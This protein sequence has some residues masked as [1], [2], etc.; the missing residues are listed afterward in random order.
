MKS[1]LTIKSRLF[2]TI[3]AILACSYAVLFFSSLF[4]IQTFIEDETSKDLELSLRFA[5]SQ[6]NA[7]PELILEVLKLPASTRE[8]QKIFMTADHEGLRESVKLWTG[9]LDFLEMLTILDSEQN[10]LVRTNRQQEPESFLRGDLLKSLY[11]RKQP[12]ITTELISHD[13]YCREVSSEVC[14]ALPENKDVMLQLVLLP[15]LD[16]SGKVIGVIAAGDDVNKDPHLPYQQQKVFGKTVDM[17]VTQA[18]ELIASTMTEPGWFTSVLEPKVL[19]VL[20]SG[21]AFHGSSVLNGH[22]YEIIAESINN[23]KGEFIGSIAVALGKSRFS[24][25][26]HD[27]FRNLII[28]GLFSV[29]AIFVFAYFV[30]RQFAAP[31]RRF[32]DAV[33]AIEAGDYSTKVPE[34]GSYEFIAFAETFNK[35][36]T[37][38]SQR[39]AIIVSQ[40]SE[41]MSL[42]EELERRVSERARQLEDETAVQK[43]II[44]SLVDGLIVADEQFRIIELNPAAEKLFGVRAADVAGEPLR[45]FCDQLDL[46][47]LGELLE[48]S[49]TSEPAE[50]ERSVVLKHNRRRLRFAAT[51]L[52]DERGSSRGLLLGIRNVTADSEVDRLKSGFIAKVSHELKTPLTSMKGSLQFILKKGKWLTGVEREMLGV[53]LRNT[54]RLIGL[55]AGILELSRIEAGQIVFSMRSLQ[56]GE[57]VLYAIEEIKESALLRNISLVND[58]PMDFPKVYGDYERLTQVLSILLSNAV[59][60]SPD[61]SVVTLSAAI[62]KSFLVLSVAD[63]GKVILEEERET[64]FS[65]FQQMGRPEEGEFCGSGLGLAIS[66]EIIERH[67]GSI[68]HAPGTAG[69]N[70]FTF[71]VPLYGEPDGKRQNTYC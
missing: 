42:N 11:E 64:L 38:L 47:E 7:R 22:D 58:V 48:I 27:N 3:V 65:R 36:T 33:K 56:I 2:F 19:H 66:K 18:G 41:L 14:R 21:F 8:L 17:F 55:V 69:G 9:T 25:L 23:H 62:E 49:S 40:N 61:N 6:L 30:A 10:V 68:C 1:S 71:T 43:S 63:N 29:A 32:S 35:M 59:K 50:N 67:G 4:T 15:V 44:K 53:C 52:K 57:V 24:G 5:K 34:N 54:E 26:R 60:Y 70:V 46:Y 20:K 51:D 13:N 45:K 12:F 31:I 37:A 39:D 16:Q 28:C